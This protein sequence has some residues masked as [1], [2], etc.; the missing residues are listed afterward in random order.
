MK[1]NACILF[2]FI[3]DDGVSEDDLEWIEE[4]IKTKSEALQVL[5]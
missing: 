3:S 4:T 2:R 1:N 5:K